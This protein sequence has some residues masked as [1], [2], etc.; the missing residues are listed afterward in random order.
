MYEILPYSHELESRWD[1]F[2]MENSMNGT[3]LQ[4]RK[5]LN[6]HPEGR[7]RDASF[8]VEKSGIIVAIVPGCNVDGK[9]V[10]HQGSTFGGPII[11]KPYYTGARLFEVLQEDIYDFC[12]T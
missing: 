2:V 4:T 3:F 10:S 12:N 11:A 8:F 9:F 6:Y 1:R 7:F 5:F